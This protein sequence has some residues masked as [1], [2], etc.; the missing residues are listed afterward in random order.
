MG[1]GTLTV[2]HCPLSF[3]TSL[4]SSSHFAALRRLPMRAAMPPFASPRLVTVAASAAAVGC[5]VAPPSSTVSGRRCSPRVTPHCT[6]APLALRGVRDLSLARC[7]FAANFLSL[8]LALVPPT[9]LADAMTAAAPPSVPPPLLS[10]TAALPYPGP[11]SLA[12]TEAVVTPR[13]TAAKSA[14]P[15]A[16]MPALAILQTFPALRRMP[17]R[18]STM[19]CP[20]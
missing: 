3:S 2:V 18:T 17:A 5:T 9:G 1:E 15:P 8:H 11:P 7:P 6:T 4:S 16:A 10:A 19:R 14:G 20:R 13:A 12:C